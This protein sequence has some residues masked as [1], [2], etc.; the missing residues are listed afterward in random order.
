MSGKGSGPREGQYSKQSRK[1]FAEGYDRI[2]GCKVCNGKGFHL[3][4]DSIQK[5]QVKTTC[6]ICNGLG[7]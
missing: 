5:R 3:D 1:A 2:W 6:L 4:Y 7:I